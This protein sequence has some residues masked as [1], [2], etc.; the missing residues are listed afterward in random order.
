MEEED[1]L[2]ERCVVRMSSVAVGPVSALLALARPMSTPESCTSRLIAAF[3]GAFRS[4]ER[5]A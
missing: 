5:A 3:R 4:H 1:S 2:A